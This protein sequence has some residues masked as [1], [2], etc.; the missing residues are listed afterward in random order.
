V[1]QDTGPILRV[2]SREPVY[3]RSTALDRYSDTEE[4]TASGIEPRPLDGAFVPGGNFTE[5]RK[6]VRVEALNLRDA[7]LVPAPTGAIEFTGPRGV[8]PLYDERTSTFTFGDANLQTGQQYRVVASTPEI[9]PRV[10]ATVDTP[11]SPELLQLP[12]QLPDEVRQLARQIVDEADATT[13]F[14]QALAIQNELRS[15][16]Y[17]LEPPAGHSGVA[18]RTFLEQRVGYCE[19]FAG[20]MAAMLRTLGIPSRVAVGFTPGTV[21]PDDPTLWTVSW[22]NAHAW[23]EVKFGGEWIAFEPTPRSD[24][25]V[26]VPTAGDLTPAQTVQ[27][28]NTTLSDRPATSTPEQLDIFDEREALENQANRAGQ[29]AGPPAIIGGAQEVSRRLTNPAVVVLIAALVIAALAMLVRIG[30]RV[31]GDSSPRSR[32]MAVRERIGRLG[33]GIGV[34]PPAWETDQEYLTRLSGGTAAGRS[35][36]LACTQARYSPECS[37]DLAEQAEH[38]GAE[39]SRNLLDGRPGWQRPLIRFRG[40]ATAGWRRL[41]HRR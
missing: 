21:S 11:A 22:A 9:N 17:S 30:R 2:R 34:P 41:R 36:A 26:L 8:R 15:W 28:P 13:P 10:A 20:T 14:T 3:L 38:A 40:D 35:L 7:V 31:S 25:N 6:E 39:L 23:V 29:E 12:E 37:V 1:A 32:I 5:R 24:G 19:Q 27:T 18:M 4:W 33:H 16:E